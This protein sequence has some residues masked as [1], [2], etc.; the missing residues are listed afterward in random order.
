MKINAPAVAKSG[1]KWFIGFISDNKFNPKSQITKLAEVKDVSDYVTLKK[2][3]KDNASESKEEEILK[4]L[5]VDK[6]Y[7]LN[8][9]VQMTSK[10]WEKWWWS[11]YNKLCFNCEK[12]C[13]QSWRVTIVNCWKLEQE[14]V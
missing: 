2:F 7:I 6:C 4:L 11:D 10:E 14:K 13:K 3:L 1:S 12:S 9:P 8:K 5:G